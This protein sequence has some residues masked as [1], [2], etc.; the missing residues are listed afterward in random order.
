MT[1]VAIAVTP[2]LHTLPTPLGD[3]TLLYTLDPSYTDRIAEA[4]AQ[5]LVIPRGFDP[6]AALEGMHGLLLS[7]GSDIHPSTY[8]VGDDGYAEEADRAVDEWE[9]A[10]IGEARRRRLPTFG[11][12][13]GMQ[14]L[15]VGHGGTLIQH[16][17]LDDHPGMG[18]LGPEETMS[19]RHPVTIDP[20][21][22]LARAIHCPTV[23][24]N[25]IHHQAV[26]TPGSLRVSARGPGGVIEALEAD[27]WPALGVQ[28]HPEKMEEPEQRGLFSWFVSQA[29]DVADR[30]GGPGRPPAA[31][32]SR[33]FERSRR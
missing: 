32:T 16:V 23:N 22:R 15:A 30:T 20:R 31:S 33:R 18:A 19:R 14:L 29:T 17:D 13:R 7:G 28:W 25:T 10:L 1:R 27:D 26:A 5:P 8:G 21:S 9:L 6:A 24:V 12:C 11:I 4:G 3:R 2:W